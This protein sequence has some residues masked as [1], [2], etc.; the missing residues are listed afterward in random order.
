MSG[1]AVP[2]AWQLFGK[3]AGLVTLG[4]I[5]FALV[6]LAVMSFSRDPMSGIPT[7]IT[8]EHYAELFAGTRWLMPLIASL[9]IGVLVGLFV[10]VVATVVGRVAPRSPIVGRIVLLSLLPLFIPGIALG[11]S[12]FIFLRMILGLSLG[13]WSIFIA[14]AVWAFP[15]SFLLVLVLTTRFDYRLLEAAADLG[16]SKWRMFWDIEMPL[17]RPAV[18]GAG[19]FGFLVSFNEGQRAIFLHGN[20][21]TLPIW[22]WIMASWKKSQLPIIISL[23]RLF[24]A[25]VMPLLAATFWTM[26]VRLEKD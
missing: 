26:M 7:G 6:W 2:R 14:H 12:L 16:A 11:A 13:F 21:T 22:N 24:L 20:A 19:I 5:Y 17:L 8:I 10:M 3:W 23:E 18:I 1:F 4:L 9:A 15:F 25:V